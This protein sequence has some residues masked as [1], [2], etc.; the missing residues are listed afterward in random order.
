MYMINP[1]YSLILKSNNELLY[2]RKNKYSKIKVK[3]NEI[4]LINNILDNELFEFQESKIFK[5][6]LKKRIIVKCEYMQ[7]NRNT[8]SYL[9]TFIDSK[10]NMNLLE[11]KKVLI[12]GLGGIG[13][14]IIN[15]LVGNGIKNF[16]ILDFDK[17]DLSNLNRQYL[18]DFNDVSK[19]KTEIITEKM[20]QKNPNVYIK[21]YQKYISNS[22]EIVKMIQEENPNILICAADTPFI[23]LRINVLKAC[24]KTNTPCLFGGVSVFSGQYGPTFITKTKMKTYL[25]KL[26]R[27][28]SYVINSNVTKA[29]FGPTNSIISAYMSLDIFML[30]LGKKQY[31]SSLNKV[32]EIDFIKRSEYET[33]KF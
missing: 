29:S 25:K 9:E 16:I 31:I 22:D 17:V 18:Y 19:N 26:E 15:H 30:L 24:I 5:E 11:K 10:V 27:V 12:I 23:D 4:T 21:Y 2:C 20:L 13:C 7:Q 32:K 3:D 33:E 6:L 1:N 28:K 14:E 8:K